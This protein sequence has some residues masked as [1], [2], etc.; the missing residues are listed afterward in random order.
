VNFIS[1]GWEEGFFEDAK[2]LARLEQVPLKLCLHFTSLSQTSHFVIRAT[3]RSSGFRYNEVFI[4]IWQN[5][6]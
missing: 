5:S 6:T 2:N 3:S 1:G 4:S